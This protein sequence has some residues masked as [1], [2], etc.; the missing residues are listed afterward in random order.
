[1]QSETC[2]MKNAGQGKG[3]WLFEG[4]DQGEGAAAAGAAVQGDGAAVEAGQAAGQG[5]TEAGAFVMAGEGG[6]ALL[7]QAENAFLVLFGNTGSRVDD[8]DVKPGM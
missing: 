3:L 5:Q 8:G 2:K 7:E 1:M 4:D 6:V